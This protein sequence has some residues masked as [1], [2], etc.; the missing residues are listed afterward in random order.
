WQ[1]SKKIDFGEELDAA[2]AEARAWKTIW[3]AGQGVTAVDDVLPVVDLVGRMK[4]EFK[5]AIEEQQAN[6]QKY[7]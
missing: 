1:Q 6:L 2:Q 3:S 5:G 7:L 4:A